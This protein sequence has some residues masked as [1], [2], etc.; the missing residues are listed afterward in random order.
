[1]DTQIKGEVKENQ[2]MYN[3][4]DLQFCK[5]RYKLYQDKNSWFLLKPLAVQTIKPKLYLAL[6][7]GQHKQQNNWPKNCLVSF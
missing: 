2:K 7:K 6:Q 4:R 5:M 3:A 1:M